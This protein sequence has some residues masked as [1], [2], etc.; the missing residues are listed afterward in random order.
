MRTDFGIADCVAGVDDDTHAF[1]MLRNNVPHAY[2]QHS[3][4][5]STIV[6]KRVQEADDGL[7]CLGGGTHTASENG[8]HGCKERNEH[9]SCEADGRQHGLG[10]VDECEFCHADATRL[11]THLSRTL[12]MFDS[13]NVKT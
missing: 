7:G 3:L 11:Q 1:A 9:A 6:A 5:A 2:P 10:H 12:W 4:A 8:D 13:K